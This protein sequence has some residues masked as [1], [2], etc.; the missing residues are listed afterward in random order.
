MLSFT[1]SLR[2]L[3]AV[4]PCDMRAGFNTLE[5]LVAQKLREDVDR[6]Q[7]SCPVYHAD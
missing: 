5:A 2:V 7:G 3:V 6:C 1:G 4:E